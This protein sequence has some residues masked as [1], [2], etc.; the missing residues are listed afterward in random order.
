MSFFVYIL[1]SHSIDKYYVGKTQHL[2]RRI[3]FHNSESNRI[4]T[5]RGRPWELRAV[6]NCETAEQSAKTELFIK[7][8]KSR[9]FI[10][11]IIAH[12]FKERI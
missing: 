2:E 11:K 10:E 9:R 3:E 6:I 8:Q 1:Y 5:R 12:G 4:W 7:K